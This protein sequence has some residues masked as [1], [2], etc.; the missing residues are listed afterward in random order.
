MSKFITETKRAQ[1]ERD[2][3]KQASPESIAKLTISDLI[4]RV[5]VAESWGFSREEA[6]KLV[7]GAFAWWQKYN[8]ELIDEENKPEPVPEREGPPPGVGG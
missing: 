3:G 2:G 7:E 8:Q 5:K 6:T 1:L 4:Q